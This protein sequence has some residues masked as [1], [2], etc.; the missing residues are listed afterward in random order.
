[1]IAYMI[2]EKIM[3]KELG[4]E[5]KTKTRTRKSEARTGRGRA[6]EKTRSE[7]LRRN[8]KITNGVKKGYMFASPLLRA[9]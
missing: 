8:K 6:E 3:L 5:T 1:M 2:N 4:L 9:R 7:F